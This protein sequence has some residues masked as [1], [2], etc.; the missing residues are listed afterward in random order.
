MESPNV[1]SV[2][3]VITARMRDER[4]CVKAVPR[5]ESAG[6]HDMRVRDVQ[7]HCQ[8]V[9]ESGVRVALAD[10]C[11]T[12]LPAGLARAPEVSETES[13]AVTAAQQTTTIIV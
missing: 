5:R 8:S 3:V 2:G 13:H 11:V 10:Q 12:P 1:G 9:T 6:T 4:Q 7:S